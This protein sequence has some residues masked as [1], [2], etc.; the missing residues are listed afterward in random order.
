MSRRGPQESYWISFSD[1]MTGLMVIFMFIALNYIIQVIEYKFVEQDIYNS[2][3]LNLKPEIDDET[4]EL[5]PDGTVRFNLQTKAK[6]LFPSDKFTMTK[7]FKNTL[8]E[9][10]PKYLK[11]ITSSHYLKNISE[12]RIEGHTDTIPP[13]KS[14]RRDSYDYNLQLSS[15]RAREVLS[16]IRNHE[17]YLSYPD[18]V[19]TRLDFLFTANGLSY[20]RALNNSKEV[21]YLAKDKSVNNDLSRRVEFKIVTSNAALVEEIVKKKE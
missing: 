12:I 11:I 21:S 20:S 5:S 17:S 2:L 15:N 6:E 16:Y 4:I 7:E 19:R 10:T 1:I 9:F 3:E 8:N 18:S 14:R 13:R